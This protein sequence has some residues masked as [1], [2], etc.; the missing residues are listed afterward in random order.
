V[1]PAGGRFFFFLRSIADSITSNIFTF[2]N[3]RSSLSGGAAGTL[4]ERVGPVGF[5]M[6]ALA[7]PGSEHVSHELLVQSVGVLEVDVGDKRPEGCEGN[8]ARGEK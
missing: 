6:S 5:M 8:F 1:L 2:L 3:A 7:S 4:V